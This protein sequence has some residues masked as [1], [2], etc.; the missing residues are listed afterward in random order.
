MYETAIFQIWTNPITH[1]GFKFSQL[2]ISETKFISKR[3][4]NLTGLLH[5]EVAL[6]Q[7]IPAFQ[8]A[9]TEAEIVWGIGGPMM[10]ESVN[11]FSHKLPIKISRA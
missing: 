9:P 2:E 8:L 5:S 6:S 1:S 10:K 3:V 11:S 4:V 7:I